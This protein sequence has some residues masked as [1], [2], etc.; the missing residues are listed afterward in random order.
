M[1][2]YVNMLLG[3]DMVIHAANVPVCIFIPLKELSME[4]FQFLN[5]EAGTEQDKISMGYK[6]NE[7][8]EK[9]F[10]YYIN[11]VNWFNDI[12]GAVL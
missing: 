3:Y 5:P 10:V 6:D 8:V 1:T 9:D 7:Y 11:P 12:F 4:F 2:V